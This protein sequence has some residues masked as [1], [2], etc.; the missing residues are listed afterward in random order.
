MSNAAPTETPLACPGEG[1]F[2]FFALDTPLQKAAA[3][4]VSLRVQLASKEREVEELRQALEEKFQELKQ[5]VIETR[6]Q[7]PLPDDACQVSVR[8]KE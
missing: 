8:P 5:A 2:F 3:E 1:G 7:T 4:F 6:I